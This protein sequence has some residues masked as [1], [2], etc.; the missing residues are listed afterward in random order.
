MDAP[1]NGFLSRTV[2]SE[3]Q[4][5]NVGRCDQSCI[6]FRLPCFR[7][8]APEQFLF[9]PTHMGDRC[10]KL[11]HDFKQPFPVHR[12]G[13]II[14][15]TQFDGFHC[16]RVGCV[17]G[18]DDKR[19]GTPFLVEPFEQR[20]PVTVRQADIRQDQVKISPADLPARGGFV[21]GGRHLEALTPQPLLLQLRQGHIIFHYQYPVLHSVSSLFR[22]RIGLSDSLSRL[23]GFPYAS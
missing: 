10:Q 15:R 21:H 7:A 9:L 8:G 14:F 17:F 22:S 16:V 20:D 2:G 3:N 18:H 5:R 4:H 19:D 12:F 11:V 13:Q 1:R 6:M 23:S